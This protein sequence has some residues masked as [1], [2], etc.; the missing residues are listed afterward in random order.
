MQVGANSWNTRK[1]NHR[2]SNGKFA[3]GQTL[4]KARI[5]F[6]TLALKIVEF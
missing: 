6:H 5:D 3:S 1:T 2:V 4:R